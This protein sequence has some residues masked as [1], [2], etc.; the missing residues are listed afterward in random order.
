MHSTGK[1]ARAEVISAQHDYAGLLLATGVLMLFFFKGC[2]DAPKICLA[3]SQS[4]IGEGKSLLS[5][6][7]E[8]NFS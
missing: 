8:E 1:A 6:L 7:E 4:R 2:P 3:N 5:S